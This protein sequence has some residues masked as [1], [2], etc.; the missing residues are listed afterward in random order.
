MR[1]AFKKALKSRLVAG[2]SRTSLVCFWQTVLAFN[3][4]AQRVALIRMATQVLLRVA[5][6]C[7]V[8]VPRAG[9]A[10]RILRF[11]AIAQR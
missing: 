7:G 3:R 2:F 9:M 8:G 11:A 10:G 1:M 4:C 6:G 5:V